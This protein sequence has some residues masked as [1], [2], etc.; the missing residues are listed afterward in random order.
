M[1]TAVSYM[2]MKGYSHSQVEKF[3]Q[4]APLPSSG[5][6]KEQRVE[7]EGQQSLE[8]SSQ[9]RRG[10]KGLAQCKDDFMLNKEEYIKTKNSR[11]SPNLWRLPVY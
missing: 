4:T 1:K 5:R 2:K 8:R 6:S 7:W 3:W 11:N 9:W 10:R